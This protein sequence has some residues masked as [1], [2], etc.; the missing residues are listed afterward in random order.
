VKQEERYKESYDL[1][2]FCSRYKS[3][4]GDTRYDNEIKKRFNKLF[5]KGIETVTLINFSGAPTD[6]TLIQENS[7]LL[8][9]ADLEAGN[10]VVALYGIRVHNFAQY[11][12]A[13][14]TSKKPLDLIVWKNNHYEQVEAD[15]PH[16]RFNARF[17][18]YS[19]KSA[20]KD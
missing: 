10:V 6:G 14:D 8:K 7:E 13:R 20:L 1:I 11:L 9:A 12:Y 3:S 5:P 16:H 15:P 2:D 4:T 17:G 18:S 19:A